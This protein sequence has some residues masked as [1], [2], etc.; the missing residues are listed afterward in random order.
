[1]PSIT[2]K[3]A[4]RVLATASLAALLA[5]CNGTGN[6]PPAI[7]LEAPA[8]AADYVIGADD[9]LSLHFTYATGL[10]ENVAVQQ[11]GRI[12]LPM[13]GPVMAGGL[14]PQQLAARV[15]GMYAD[16]LQ[17]PEVVVLVKTATSQRVFIDGEVVR[18][19][20]VP[21]SPEMT[22]IGAI[23][24][25]GGLKDSAGLSDIV[26]LRHDATGTEHAYRIDFTR[27]RDGSDLAQNIRLA[28]RD[29][30][31]VPKSGAASV[32]LIVKQLIHDNIPIGLGLPL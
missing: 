27:I 23:T 29:V 11:D 18:P 17:R 10:D 30:V 7:A 22:L 4:G 9:E 28:T 32:N 20:V 5:G 26:L 31:L 8:P 25:A 14:T 13:M 19:G 1:M 3:H 24:A 16:T 12:A 21:L 6:L 15:S 2:F